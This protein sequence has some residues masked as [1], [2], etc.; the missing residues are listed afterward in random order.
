VDHCS[1]VFVREHCGLRRIVA[2]DSKE[3]VTKLSTSA[4]RTC[5]A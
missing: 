3:G 5:K 4:I 2:Q 1:I